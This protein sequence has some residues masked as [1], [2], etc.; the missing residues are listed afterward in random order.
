MFDFPWPVRLGLLIILIAD[1]NYFCAHKASQK[2]ISK[3]SRLTYQ[4][5][6][7]GEV[8]ERLISITG[9]K[10]KIGFHSTDRPQI[11]L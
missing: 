6:V 10:Y 11:A 4:P 9:A 8:I 2:I 5:S 7:Y 3:A 1:Q